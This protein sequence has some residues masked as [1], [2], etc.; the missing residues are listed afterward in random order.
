MIEIAT[1]IDWLNRD[2]NIDSYWFEPTTKNNNLK[3]KYNKFVKRIEKQ[4]DQFIEKKSRK[5]VF[6][7]DAEKINLFKTLDVIGYNEEE[8]PYTPEEIM[9]KNYETFLEEMRKRTK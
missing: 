9:N 2:Q 1:G 7:T 5:E 6:L 3:K 8:R 4:A